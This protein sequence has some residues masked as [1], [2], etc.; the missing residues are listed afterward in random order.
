MTSLLEKFNLGN[1]VESTIGAIARYD[2]AVVPFHDGHFEPPLRVRGGTAVE[3]Y[4]PRPTQ[5]MGVVICGTPLDGHACWLEV[6]G[7]DA[8]G[9]G[10]NKYTDGYLPV[11]QEATFHQIFMKTYNLM[12]TRV[13]LPRDGDALIS[14]IHFVGLE[15]EL[16]DERKRPFLETIQGEFRCSVWQ[17]QDNAHFHLVNNRADGQPQKVKLALTRREDGTAIDEERISELPVGETV[18]S[19]PLKGLVRGD[20]IV[21]VADASGK[22]DASFRRL[23]RFHPAPATAAVTELGDVTGQKLFFPDGHYFSEYENVAFCGET[24]EHVQVVPPSQKNE[25]FARYGMQIGLDE[26]GRPKIDY[27]TLNRKWDADSVRY[28]RATLVDETSGRWETDE[29]PERPAPDPAECHVGETPAEAERPEWTPRRRPPFRFYDATHDGVPRP[30]QI[31]FRYSGAVPNKTAMWKNATQ[32]WG[33]RDVRP[34]AVYPLWHKENGD[35]VMLRREH[36]LWDHE[37]FGELEDADATHDNFAGQ[38]LAKGG[39]MACYGQ[40]RWL[41]TYPP[42]QSPPYDNMRGLRIMGLWTTTNGFDYRHCGFVSPDEDEPPLCQQYQ[43]RVMPLADGNG[44][45][46]GFLLRYLSREQTLDTVLCYSWD[47]VDWHRVNGAP[48]LPVGKPGSWNCG[49]VELDGLVGSDTFSPLASVIHRGKESWLLTGTTTGYYHFEAAGITAFVP[50]VEKVNAD[51]IRNTLGQNGIEE[52]PYFREMGGYEGLAHHAKT[53]GCSIA[54]AKMRRDGFFRV[55]AA[56]PSASARFITVPLRAHG[57][58]AANVRIEQGGWM[59]VSL[60]DRAGRLPSMRT[61]RLD[62]PLDEVDLQIFEQLSP[63]DFRI[64]VVMKGARLYALNL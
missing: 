24:A 37:S 26:Q 60:L 17:N 13:L 45:R 53:A 59:E 2:G 34:R 31:E 57:G 38:W 50:D 29:L 1:R 41:K 54:Y 44:L 55:E 39:A 18:V 49:N 64:S 22:T 10:E 25:D 32:A 36:L 35:V 27:F 48:F 14:E 9:S 46:I 15:K 62:G 30:S 28:M 16:V 63:G 52:W 42:F 58:L 5:T 19:F 56:A 11:G 47:G 12:F 43:A 8:A 21:T 3:I 7:C 40:A 51:Y 23:L 33:C 61:C 6:Y 4:F 20:Y